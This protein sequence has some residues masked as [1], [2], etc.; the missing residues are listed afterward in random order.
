MPQL[1][2]KTPVPRP[3][4]PGPWAAGPPA[5]DRPAG[6]VSAST[7]WAG[8]GQDA[9]GT[10]PL[11]VLH[12][13]AIER[14]TLTLPSTL[15]GPTR[16][17]VALPMLALRGRL[18]RRTVSDDTRDRV[19]RHLGELA[20]AQRGDWNLFAL[21]MAYPGMRPL[22][23]K[24]TERMLPPHTRAFHFRFAS[25]FLFALHRL[26]LDRPHV[27][28][29]L[30]GA[31]YDQATGRKRRPQPALI[32]L[33]T[34]DLDT[35]TEHTIT[36]PAPTPASNPSSIDPDTVLHRLVKQ[37]RDAADGQRLTPMQATL[38]ARTYLDGETLRTVAA[39]LGLS[40]SNASKHRR[41][42]AE[43]IAH[44]LGR[45]DLLPAGAH[46][47]PTREVS[48]RDASTRRAGPADVGRVSIDRLPR[49]K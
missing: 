9:G 22:A 19:W 38:I 4:R 49:Q 21:G 32:D 34:I 23:W 13:L 24:W 3:T 14:L 43:L 29:R 41:R 10:M 11:G 1:V 47:T 2:P 7:E 16:P 26:R 20:R 45:D 48:A 5:T 31:A 25:E 36:N 27:I 18:M 37:T 39:E 28:G 46:T 33:D 6:D 30:I 35:L 15:L 8:T 40:E 44:Q 17:A 42:A 12:R